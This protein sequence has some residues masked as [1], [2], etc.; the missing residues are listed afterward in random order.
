MVDDS[1]SIRRREPKRPPQPKDSGRIV[2]HKKPVPP[3]KNIY[4]TDTFKPPPPTS[5]S[6]K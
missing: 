3:D 6:K 2:D 4:I 5:P 1:E